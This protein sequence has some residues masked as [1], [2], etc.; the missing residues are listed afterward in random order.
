MAGT[1]TH[2]CANVPIRAFMRHM[3]FHALSSAGLPNS[4]LGAPRCAE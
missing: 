2:E 1:A 4:V 3:M